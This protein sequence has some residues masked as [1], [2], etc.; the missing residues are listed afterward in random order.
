MRRPPA[1]FGIEHQQ[2]IDPKATVPSTEI[3]TEN[4][5]KFLT[6]VGTGSIA[7]FTPLLM[8]VAGSPSVMANPAT[9]PGDAARE[10]PDLLVVSDPLSRITLIGLTTEKPRSGLV[11]F[12]SITVEESPLRI[13]EFRFDPDFIRRLENLQVNIPGISTIDLGQVGLFELRVDLDS[14]N[15]S[16]ASGTLIDPETLLHVDFLV[17]QFELHSPFSIGRFLRRVVAV[18]VSVV[19]GVVTGGSVWLTTN[20][21]DCSERAIKG[22]GGTGVLQWS[23]MVTFPPLKIDCSFTCK[24]IP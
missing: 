3:L 18:A 24:P 1:I 2:F 15:E 13:T 19:V 4:R 21:L 20:W 23:V 7:A 14:M 10:P 12:S 8:G 16:V 6:N 17:R 5:R 9:N 22:C 11:T